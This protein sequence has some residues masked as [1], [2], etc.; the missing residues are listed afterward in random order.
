MRNRRVDNGLTQFDWRRLAQWEVLQREGEGA[1]RGSSE[2]RYGGG[3]GYCGRQF[4]RF[5]Y[6]WWQ[7]GFISLVKSSTPLFSPTFFPSSI[8]S[9]AK[10]FQ[11]CLNNSNKQRPAASSTLVFHILFVQPHLTCQLQMHLKTALEQLEGPLDFLNAGIHCLES[12]PV[13]ISIN[14][15]LILLRQHHHLLQFWMQFLTSSQSSRL[16]PTTA[17]TSLHHH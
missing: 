3:C 6:Y 11:D 15:T 10:A 16:C 12:I 17:A 8:K 14:N 9:C 5:R 13:L 4:W 2:T 1:A 7:G